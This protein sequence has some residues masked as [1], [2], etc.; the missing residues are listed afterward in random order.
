MCAGGRGRG[1]AGDKNPDP[2]S[3]MNLYFRSLEGKSPPSFP[4]PHQSYF[5]TNMVCLH[6]SVTGNLTRK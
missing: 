1:G 2:S 3:K 5:R 4:P 6:I